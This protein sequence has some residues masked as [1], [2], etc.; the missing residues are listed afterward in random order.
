VNELV[1]RLHPQRRVGGSARGA[2]QT[3]RR[4]DPSQACIELEQF[5][6]HDWKRLPEGTG[7]ARISLIE[8][9]GRGHTRAH[10]RWATCPELHRIVTSFDAE[11]LALTLARLVPGGEVHEHRDLS[12]GLSMGVIRLHLPLISDP[13]VVFMVDGQRVRMQPGEIWQLDTTHRHRVRHEGE[14][15]RIHMIA[16]LRAS[17]SLRALLP[18]TEPGD[19]L[20]RV[21]FAGVCVARGAE[22]ALRSP[23]ALV[24][25]VSRFARL[26][27]LGQSGLTFEDPPESSTTVPP[28]TVPS[29]VPSTTVPFELACPECGSADLQL[30]EDLRP[31]EPPWTSATG[32]RCAGCARE[33]P[34]VDGVWVLWS[35]ALRALIRERP[36]SDDPE[37]TAKWANFTVYEQMSAAY[38]DHADHSDAYAEQLAALDRLA[39]SRPGEGTL[40]DVGCANGFA[41]DRLAARHARTIGVDLS[42]ASLRQVAARGHVAVLGD[43]ERLPL[44]AGTIDRVTCFAA[45]HHFP[46]PA[47]FVRSA[48]AALRTG[49]VLLTA[50]DPSRA[51]MHMGPLARAAWDVRRPVYRALARVLPNANERSF[52]HA[53]RDRQ[54]LNELAEHH[55]TGGGFEPDEL[56]ATLRAAGFAEV[57]VFLDLDRAG[58]QQW[59]LPSW[60]M[61]VLK[62]LSGQH[63]LR[64]ANWATLSSLA[65][66]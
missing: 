62:G 23:T 47:A 16:D 51:S 4:W 41:L 31:L 6:E 22:L 40:V 57:E 27:L 24:D 28:T 8:P 50:A 32:L 49:G 18:E 34:R 14:R 42:L 15:A 37:A 59:G 43:A 56:A 44:A 25:R 7:W 65:R 55:R 48:R 39:G 46:D 9:D 33:Y 29:T 63:P 2:W 64:R 38:G 35:D 30:T 11:I 60:Q 19:W 12:G 21:Q 20:H 5:D 36:A 10:P 17:E 1:E 58:E 53:D 52:L 13:G 61:A 26:R 54:Q 45:L 3:D 66:K